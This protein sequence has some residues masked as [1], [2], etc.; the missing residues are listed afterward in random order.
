M[1][2][3]N[4]R[5]ALVIVREIEDACQAL[6]AAQGDP[7]ASPEVIADIREELNDLER[8]LFRTG[9]VSEREQ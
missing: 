9:V 1:S 3:P 6:Y 8:E 2:R 4:Y 7:T 5:R